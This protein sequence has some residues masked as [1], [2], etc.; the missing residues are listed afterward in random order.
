MSE[1]RPRACCVCGSASCAELLTARERMFG[2]GGAFPYVQCRDCG[3][4]QIAAIPPDLGRYY[5]D[6]YYSFQAGAAEAG[7]FKRAVRRLRDRHALFGSGGALGRWLAA[8]FPYPELAGIGRVRGLTLDTRILDVGCGAGCL[9]R[10]LHGHGFTSLAGVDPFIPA[11]LDAAPGVRVLKR[12][13]HEL[14]GLWDLVM[15]HHSL[16]H[17][18]DPTA[19]LR[20]CLARLAPGG[21]MLIRVPIVPSA[22][23]ERYRECWVGL[24][25]P[26]H[27]FIPSL[28]GIERM[29][30]ALGLR[31]G[32]VTHD[33]TELQFWGSERYLQDLPLAPRAEGGPQR[34]AFPARRLAAWRREARRLNEAGRGDQAAIVLM[35]PP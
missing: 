2:L 16:E 31:V 7:G 17:V 21:Q 33:S 22:A 8:R 11:D 32:P 15:F 20:H 18:P 10:A 5:T 12:H 9:L 29:A 35:S 23:F 1:P 28:A 25:A 4:L 26:R 3:S 14:E 19:T 30:R 34:D 13:V 6:G 27:L 24:D